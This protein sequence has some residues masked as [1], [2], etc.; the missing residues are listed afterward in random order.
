M[1]AVTTDGP[2]TLSNLLTEEITSSTSSSNKKR[3][4][5]DTA[6]VITIAISKYTVSHLHILLF[7]F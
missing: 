1:H 5:N 3:D 7:I 4:V 6:Q 2:T